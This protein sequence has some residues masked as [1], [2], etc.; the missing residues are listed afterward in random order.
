M[1]LDRVNRGVAPKSK[2]FG[3][4]I[5]EKKNYSKSAAW[6]FAYY[7]PGKVRG[8]AFRK[9]YTADEFQLNLDTPSLSYI[10]G[11]HIYTKLSDA[12]RIFDSFFNDSFLY[13]IVKV[14]YEG[15]HTG[16]V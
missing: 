3:Y 9:W 11:F 10:S 16:G 2:G 4:K 8:I 15:A 13:S 14:Q 6:Y 7:S 12:Q 1:C 5:I